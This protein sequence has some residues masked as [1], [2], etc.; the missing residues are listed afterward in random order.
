MQGN[1]LSADKL[2]L[3]FSS[4]PHIATYFQENINKWLDVKEELKFRYILNLI[5]L[6]LIKYQ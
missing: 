5:S 4:N 1:F 3:N 6:I 2:L